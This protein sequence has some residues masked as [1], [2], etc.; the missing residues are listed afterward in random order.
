MGRERGDSRVTPGG[1]ALPSSVMERGGGAGPAGLGCQQM[2]ERSLGFQEEARGDVLLPGGARLLASWCL[3]R[4]CISWGE[5]R[6]VLE[7]SFTSG[8]SLFHTLHSLA[9]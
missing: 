2:P 9:P 1:M 4:V 7:S 6:P 3:G 5:G 8:A